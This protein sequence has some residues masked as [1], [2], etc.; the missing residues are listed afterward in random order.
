[1][2]ILQT[3]IDVAEADVATKALVND[4]I[5]PLVFPSKATFPCITARIISGYNDNVISEQVNTTRIQFDVWSYTYLLTAQVK[6]A[7][8]ALFNFYSG[9]VNSQVIISTKVD[10]T[11]DTFEQN[12]KA[13]RTVID[14]RVTHEGD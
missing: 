13:H 11:F 2:G 14:V 10:L 6:A 3:M 1:M 9:T 4:R 12:I 5:Y 7:L 8:M